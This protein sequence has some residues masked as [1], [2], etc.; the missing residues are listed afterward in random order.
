MTDGLSAKKYWQSSG[1][2]PFQRLFDKVIPFE[3]VFEDDSIAT[4]TV[5]DGGA[6]VTATGAKLG[7]FVLVASEADVVDK[8]FQATV[9]A[10]NAVTIVLSN[11]NGSTDTDYASGVVINGIVLSLSDFWNTGDLT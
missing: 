8:H 9:T 2:I 11:N 6:T 4:N 7:D 10:A 5:Y 3:V 1:K